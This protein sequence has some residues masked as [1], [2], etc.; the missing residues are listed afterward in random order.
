MRTKLI[1]RHVV[2]FSALLLLSGICPSCSHKAVNHEGKTLRSSLEH[3]PSDQHQQLEALCPLPPPTGFVNDYA[4]VLAPAA[5]ARLEAFFSELREKTDIEF[6]VVT[7]ETTGTQPIFDYSLAVVRGWG[8]GPQETSKGG[9][10]LL[11]LAIKD[12]QWR[13]QVSRGLEKDLPDEVSKEL[14]EQSKELYRQGKYADGVIKY[15]KV[16]IER[17]ERV[18][19]FKLRREL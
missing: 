2:A 15:V 10:L 19:G 4:H 1:A 18:R 5:K 14:G 16:I 12:R 11:L 6:A 8:V 17:L 13:L 9:G 7:V 3:A